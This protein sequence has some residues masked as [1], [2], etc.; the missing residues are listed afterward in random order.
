[1]NDTYFLPLYTS[2]GNKTGR[3]AAEEDTF[4]TFA[5]N[6]RHAAI[7]VISL[8]RHQANC[9]SCL[10]ATLHS[11]KPPQAFVCLLG[12]LLSFSCPGLCLALLTVITMCQD[13]MADKIGLAVIG[14]HNQGLKSRIIASPQRW[15]CLFLLY[16][17]LSFYFSG[18][19][20]V[21]AQAILDY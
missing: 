5:S 14:N 3:G 20:S 21:G 1:M 15:N 6:D 9:H 12:V 7:T 11:R 19:H 2:A 10:A 17:C 13:T 8:S 4:F 18:M 16:A